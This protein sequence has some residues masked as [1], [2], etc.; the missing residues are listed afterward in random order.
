MTKRFDYDIFCDNEGVVRVLLLSSYTQSSSNV[1]KLFYTIDGTEPTETSPCIFAT[2]KANTVYTLN[3]INKDIVLY[4]K[5]VIKFKTGAYNSDTKSIELDDETFMFT[6]FENKDYNMSVS[7]INN[8]GEKGTDTYETINLVVNEPNYNGIIAQGSIYITFDGTEPSKDNYEY[9]IYTHNISN[10]RF[11]TLQNCVAK[12][13]VIYGDYKSNVSEFTI[14]DGIYNMELPVI[15]LSPLNID[16]K[17]KNNEVG[18]YSYT[19]QDNVGINEQETKSNISKD[20]NAVIVKAK[21][22]RIAY[23]VTTDNG[24]FKKYYWTTEI[25]DK[26][27]AIKPVISFIASDKPNE[28]YAKLDPNNKLNIDN[29]KVKY[30]VNTSEY[31]DYVS[32]IKLVSNDILRYYNTDE[33]SYSSIEKLEVGNIDFESPILEYDAGNDTLKANNVPALPEWLNYYTDKA[34]LYNNN[35]YHLGIRTLPARLDDNRWSKIKVIRSIGIRNYTNNSYVDNEYFKKE[36]I[37]TSLDI[38][39]YTAPSVDYNEDK[40]EVV[41]ISNGSYKMYMTTNGSTPTINSTPV[42][43]GDT[44]KPK[45]GNVIRVVGYDESRQEY[46]KVTVYVFKKLYS[47]TITVDDYIRVNN[48]NTVGDSQIQ[49]NDNGGWITIN[50][51]KN[52]N[53]RT[54][55]CRIIYKDGANIY[56]SKTVYALYI[57]PYVVPPELKVDED[58]NVTIFQSTTNTIRYI[59]NSHFIIPTNLGVEYNGESI[60]L[61]SNDYIEAMTVNYENNYSKIVSYF[62]S[63]D[64]VTSTGVIVDKLDS[65]KVNKVNRKPYSYFDII[66]NDNYEIPKILTSIS[67]I[68][69]T[70]NSNFDLINKAEENLNRRYSGYRFKVYNEENNTGI[71]DIETHDTKKYNSVSLNPRAYKYPYWDRGKWN[72][73]YIRNSIAYNKP[74]DESAI[75]YGKYFVARFI[76]DNSVKYKFESINFITNNE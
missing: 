20:V 48:P 41:V 12:A 9:R 35:H 25:S 19:T 37:I 54:V 66:S 68:V 61:K 49:I 8:V 30:S 75:L 29:Y 1:W 53:F 72:F 60:K 11:I 70:I 17:F 33:V 46:T 7:D 55:K 38:I 28:I 32:P 42:N 23:S 57:K 6:P 39:T 44:L 62:Y 67:Y 3:G 27:G 18:V 45:F 74:S 14:G 50:S 31:K 58:G 4:T 76:F 24:T 69:N 26:R 15:T 64:Y 59:I 71:L 63:K 34:Y 65:D 40:E 16:F 47:P 5:P 52:E 21:K 2:D 43:S 10:G 73:D 13:V 51:I 22:Y 36:T 56:E